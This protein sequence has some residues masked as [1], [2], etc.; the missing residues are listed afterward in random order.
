MGSAR[1]LRGALRALVDGGQARNRRE[2][3]LLIR[4]YRDQRRGLD[5]KRAAQRLCYR[6][7]TAH[8]RSQLAAMARRWSR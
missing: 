1:Y 6:G 2:A 8:R 4:C 5:W 3:A 7:V